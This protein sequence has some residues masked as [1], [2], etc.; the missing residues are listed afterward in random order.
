M[1]AL[2]GAIQMVLMFV[3]FRYDT[4]ISLKQ[5]GDYDNL[6]A[7]M[8]RLYVREQVQMRMDEIQVQRTGHT[9]ENG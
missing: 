9:D 8:K 5:R 1:P 4:P 2:I 7:L 3:V 6:A